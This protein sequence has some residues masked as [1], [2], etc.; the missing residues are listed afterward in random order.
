[1]V[2]GKSK[3]GTHRFSLRPIPWRNGN[4]VNFM[5]MSPSKIGNWKSWS[6]NFEKWWFHW[7]SMEKM[8]VY[9][10]IYIYI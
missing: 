9:N 7:W 3:T 1:L 4:M 5:V 6:G 2:L 10:C 8:Y